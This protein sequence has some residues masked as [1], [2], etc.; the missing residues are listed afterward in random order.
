MYILFVWEKTS[1][2]K[3]KRKKKKNLTN[4][5]SLP[6]T[7]HFMHSKNTHCS[8][9]VNIEIVTFPPSHYVEFNIFFYERKKN[10]VAIFIPK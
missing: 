8:P 6:I 5:L 9:V 3:R 4:I 1:T 7:L 10:I 2:I